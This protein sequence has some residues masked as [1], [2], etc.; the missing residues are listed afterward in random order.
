[1]EELKSLYVD[2]PNWNQGI[3]VDDFI[4]AIGNTKSNSVYHVFEVNARP[5][6]DKRITRYN[7]KVLKSDLL[8]ALKRDINQKLIPMQWYKRNKSKK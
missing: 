6:R 1:M 7:L 3:A 8:T 4:I 5:R 2:M